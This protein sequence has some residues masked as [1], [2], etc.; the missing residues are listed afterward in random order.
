MLVMYFCM[1]H[2]C[3]LLRCQL[4]YE[5]TVTET[6]KSRPDIV[7]DGMVYVPLHA[8]VALDVGVAG[9]GHVLL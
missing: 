6:V 9:V 8:H 3:F 4:D 5:F 7:Y 1:P 2:V